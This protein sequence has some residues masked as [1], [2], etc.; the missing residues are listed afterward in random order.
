MAFIVK[1][2]FSRVI[3]RSQFL[4]IKMEKLGSLDCKHLNVAKPFFQEDIWCTY[5]V[6][7]PYLGSFQV[8]IKILAYLLY[9]NNNE[10]LLQNYPL[11]ISYSAAKSRIQRGRLKLQELLQ[12]C[13]HIESD[14]YGNIVN[15][16]ITFRY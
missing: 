2:L 15:F 13:C 6:E 11:R 10:H 9:L 16:D 8:R 14:S 5:L 1:R 3:K 4:S 12:G 7:V